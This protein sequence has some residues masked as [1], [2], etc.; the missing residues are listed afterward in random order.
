MEWKEA[1]APLIMDLIFMFTAIC[2]IIERA[3]EVVDFGVT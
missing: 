2:L 3:N 1:M